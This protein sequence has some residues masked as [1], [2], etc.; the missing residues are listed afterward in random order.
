MSNEEQLADESEITST[1]LRSCIDKRSS[2]LLLLESRTLDLAMLMS[3]L[4]LD[5]H[6]LLF[7]VS[8]TNKQ[9]K[10]EPF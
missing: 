4:M 5:I 2:G 1:F 9:N 8:K 7:D 3:S 6:L 10:N